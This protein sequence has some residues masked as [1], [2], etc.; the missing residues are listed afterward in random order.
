MAA[1]ARPD[2][3]RRDRRGRDAGHGGGGPAHELRARTGSRRTAAR[4]T[5]SWP[6]RRRRSSSRSCRAHPGWP[7]WRTSPPTD[8]SSRTRP[9]SSR[10][11]RRPMAGSA[12]WSIGTGWWPAARLTQPRPTR[13]PSARGWRRASGWPSGSTSTSSRTPRRRSTTSSSHVPDV[14]Q[15]AGPRIRLRVVGIVR[16]PLD[17]GE[18]MASGGLVVLSRAFGPHYGDRVGVFGDRIRLR[19]DHGAADVPEVV[20]ASKRIL[21]D[22]LFIAQGLAVDAQGASNAI[23]VLALALWIGAG[24]AALA[25][26]VTIAIVLTREVS[27]V[28][29]DLETL[30]ELGC[31]RRQLVA[32]SAVPGLVVAAGGGLLAGV[33]AVAASPLF[34]FGVAAPRRPDG[35]PPRRLGGAAARRRRGRARGPGDRLRRRPPSDEVVLGP[36]GRVAAGACVGR[37]RP[38]GGR[39][40]GAAVGE[41]GADGARAGAWPDR[42]AGPN[43]L[44]GRGGRR[45]RCHGGP[46]L[47]RERRPSRRDPR[48]LRSAVGLQGG[49][50]HVEHAVRSGRLRPRPAGRHRRARRGLHPE[51]AGRRP[52]GG[53]HG[54]HPAPGAGH[55]ARGDGRTPAER[56]ERGR[57]GRQDAAR[58]GQ[59]PRR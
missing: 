44:R 40:A 36:G 4:P 21:G 8:W 17:L 50:H 52:A 39:R 14:G 42:G 28:S 35:R 6:G 15:P 7:R 56:P 33:L 16:R 38:D 19:T 26:V 13:S 30:H 29:V 55:R 49:R 20:A 1:G 48:T 24:V 51:R 53:R 31:D 47:Q 11:A 41:R 37:G 45:P 54:L 34:P 59:A 46:R 12:T 3:A 18:Q 43:G 23:D 22:S 27:L 10:S 57:A 2:R 5:S 9:T 25:G 58:A 32:V